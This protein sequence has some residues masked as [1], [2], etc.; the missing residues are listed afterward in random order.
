SGEGIEVRGA[1]SPVLTIADG[2][3]VKFASSGYLRTGY[4]GQP[5]GLRAHR[6]AFTSANDDTLGDTNGDGASTGSPGQWDALYLDPTTVDAQTVVDSC[7]VRFAGQ[8]GADA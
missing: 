1:G 2:T 8:G 3:V 5:G 4:N 7:L 6:V